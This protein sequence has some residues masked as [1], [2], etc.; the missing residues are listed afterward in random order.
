MRSALASSKSGKA[1]GPS[2]VIVEMLE[3]SGEAGLQWVTDI[4]NE[5]IKGGKMPEDW[6]KSWIVSVYKGK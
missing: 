1:A 5:V 6:Q 2:G 3:A 4:C